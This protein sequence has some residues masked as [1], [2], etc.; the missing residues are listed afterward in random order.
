MDAREASQ[1]QGSEDVAVDL[2]GNE[3]E[4][5]DEDGQRIARSRLRKRQDNSERAPEQRAEER[6]R[7]QEEGDHADKE[8]HPEP[9]QPETDGY[10]PA[11]EQAC[12]ELATHVTRKCPC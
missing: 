6:H 3:G 8:R 7:L 11:D 9:D 10:N 4:E 5:C 12:K 1:D 2:L